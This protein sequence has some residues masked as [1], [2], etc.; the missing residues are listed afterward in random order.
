VIEEA[1][2]PHISDVTRRALHDYACRVAEAAGLRGIATC[3]FLLGPDEAI[4]FLEV[5]PRIQVEHPVTELVTGVDLVEWQLL[6]ASGRSIPDTP[7]Y[8]QRGHA[9]EARIY[10]E[11][12]AL[13]F[14]PVAGRLATVAWPIGPAIR[15]DAG[16]TSGD[17]VPTTYDAM[18]AKVIALGGDRDAALAVLR[19]A[20]DDTIVAGATTNLAWLQDLLDR[21]AVQRGH[22]TTATAG[23]VKV[24]SAPR[25]LSP[26]A[27]VARTVDAASAAATDPWSAIGPWRSSG[28][29]TVVVHGDDWEERL[30]LWRDG[31][32]WQATMGDI[33]SRIRWWR[34]PNGVWTIVASESVEKYAVVERDGKLV[35]YGSHGH[36]DVGLGPRPQRRAGSSTRMADGQ[37]RAPLPANVM[38]VH[39]S[40]GDTVSRGD[41][42]VTLSAMKME[43]V[44]DAPAK[45]TVESVSCRAG[46]LVAADQIL[47]TLMWA[48]GDSVS[49]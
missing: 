4:S 34:G 41:P 35:V 8:E 16:Y 39:V 11:D 14:L 5:N 49:E 12:P 17:T 28:R 45:A 47:V 38:G 21:D 3:E 30:S 44:C 7:P 6:I 27:V 26:V 33:P 29:A 20:L 9:I 37:I 13:D 43:L 32:G 1:P 19:V 10:A 40:P 31:T 46:D 42:L 24:G 36:L 48:T 23:R 25:G 22:A 2:A 18:L 15:V